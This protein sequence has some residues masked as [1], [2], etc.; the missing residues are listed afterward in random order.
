MLIKVALDGQRKSSK[1]FVVKKT[2]FG[3][4]EILYKSLNCAQQFSENSKFSLTEIEILVKNLNF[5]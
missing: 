1:Y 2:I 3:K 5:A 4:I